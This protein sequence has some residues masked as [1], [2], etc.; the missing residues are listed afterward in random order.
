MSYMDFG[1]D[2]K[3]SNEVTRAYRN[4]FSSRQGPAVLR[5]ML[6]EL[7]FFDLFAENETERAWQDYAKR[8]LQI[9]GIWSPARVKEITEALL[10]EVPPAYFSEEEE[11]DAG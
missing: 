3:V 7:G 6:T 4:V 8:I 9:L 1:R 10:T 2:P 5:H 11:E